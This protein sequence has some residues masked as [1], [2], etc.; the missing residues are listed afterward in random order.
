M[1]YV[2]FVA[3][4]TVE[5][6][7]DTIQWY[8]VLLV[9][10]DESQHTRLEKTCNIA[11]LFQ[12]TTSPTEGRTWHIGVASPVENEIQADAFIHNLT[13]ETKTRGCSS[14][15]VVFER[16]ARALGI[17]V[18]NDFRTIFKNTD[19]E[20]IVQRVPTTAM[21]RSKERRKASKPN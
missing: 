1:A 10:G 6:G 13:N 3:F 2:D 5:A 7:S 19:A 21:Q 20:D 9:A 11:Q 14:R 12:T 15:S 8:V 18:Y 17:K 4:K 16:T